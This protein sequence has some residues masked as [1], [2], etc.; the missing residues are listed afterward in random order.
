MK[1]STAIVFPKEQ[2]SPAALSRFIRTIFYAAY[3]QYGISTPEELADHPYPGY[4]TI[5]FRDLNALPVME[6]LRLNEIRTK[7]IEIQIPPQRKREN[8]AEVFDVVSYVQQRGESDGRLILLVNRNYSFVGSGL[9]RYIYDK[10]G[11]GI[12]PLT[13]W[14]LYTL[15]RR[16]QERDFEE[17]DALL[18]RYILCILEGKC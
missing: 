4:Y 8:P 2:A 16:Y 13:E 5:R 6:V 12:V 10:E 7:V 11:I 3:E 15:Y 9:F 14:V 18:G 1:T 17:F